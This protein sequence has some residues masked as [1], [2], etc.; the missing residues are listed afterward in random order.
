LSTAALT[1]MITDLNAVVSSRKAIPMTASISQVILPL[2]WLVKSTLP[3]VVPV[4]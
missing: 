2:I 3:A 1:A 4:T